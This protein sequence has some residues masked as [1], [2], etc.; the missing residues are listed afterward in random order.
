MKS[1]F[2]YIRVSTPKQ[3]EG[4]S[5]E[6]QKDDIAK[7]AL[8]RGLNIVDWFVELETAAKT[9]RPVFNALASKLKRGQA[10]ALMVHKLDRSSRN[11][12][13]WGAVSRLMDQGI[14]FHIAT[15]Q[16]DFTTRSGRFT[17]DML[18]AIAADFS[19]NQREETK[20]GLRGRLKQGLFPYRP[21]LGYLAGGRGKP[22]PNCPETGPIVARMFDLYATGDHSY[23]SLR[24]EAHRLGLRNHNGG[25]ISL[26]G[27]E[28][29]LSNPFYYG[30]IRIERTG[31]TFQGVHEPLID[32]GLFNKVQ[33]IRR[34]RSGAKV[35]RHKHLFVGLFRCSLCSAPLVPELQ[36]GHV[37]YRCHLRT[38]KMTS[39]R[40]DR[41]DHEIRAE[42]A[43]LELTREAADEMVRSWKASDLAD[44][45]SLQRRS[46]TAKIEDRETKKA[47]LADLLLEEAI[48]METHKLKRDEMDFE[49]SQLRLRL[50]ELPDPQSVRRER[51]KFLD[52]MSNLVHLYDSSDRAGKRQLLRET[53]SRRLADKSAIKLELE[54]W[55]NAKLGTGDER[56]LE[57]SPT[58][59]KA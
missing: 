57:K 27:M 31:E 25:L 38:C 21:P 42:L 48:D 59:T 52:W 39:I 13:D 54:Q 11:M 35:T 53:F 3:G 43:R 5:L 9:G 10:E 49:L 46:I 36:R 56:Q 29:M 45:L 50:E 24:H 23:E 34:T 15:E 17:A 58:A 33:S 44:E 14:E 8:E 41:L 6:V 37:Y 26:H 1:C 7:A 22:K 40:E 2:G 28:K 19:R 47:R 18:A 30:T 16:I 51:G 4:V 20:K 55:A 12:T 32:K